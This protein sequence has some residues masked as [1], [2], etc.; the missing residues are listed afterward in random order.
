MPKGVL[1]C[2]TLSFTRVE[3]TH[4]FA[5]SAPEFML[6]SRHSVIPYKFLLP[7]RFC[8]SCCA[9]Q[10]SG[11]KFCWK[12]GSPSQCPLSGEGAG[13]SSPKTS[14]GKPLLLQG[15]S[16][17]KSFEDY[18]ACKKKQQQS[19][20]KFR[21]KKKVKVNADEV[22]TINIGLMR[23]CENDLKAIWGKRL[24]IQVVKS[25]GY[26]RILSKGMEKW[27][28]F[29]RKFDPEED[30]VLLFEDGSHAVCLPGQEEDFQLEKYKTELGKDYKRITMYLCTTA[31]FEMSEDSNPTNSGLNFFEPNDV[32]DS[33]LANDIE[34][35]SV[36]TPA[37]SSLVKTS[38]PPLS[39]ESPSTSGQELDHSCSNV[40]SAEQQILQDSQLAH[41]LQEWENTSES[42]QEITDCSTTVVAE[43]AQIVKILSERVDRMQEFFLVS[44]RCA[45]FSR[46][47]ALWQRQT[48]KSPPTSVLKVHFNGEAGIDTGAMSQGF[49]AEVISDM[50]REVF[51]DG[52]PTDSTYYVQN[53]TF[54]TCGEI[55]A[56]S[57]AQGGPPP[58]FLEQCV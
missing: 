15:K 23:N 58:C 56:V 39:Y 18:M 24:P 19:G 51:P 26:A 42:F 27:A 22:V 41:M 9:K 21:L 11:V 28:A 37:R 40:Q 7:S 1:H 48:K 31:E 44:R 55:V 30:H 52:S 46:T 53:G 20:A 36:T 38:T 45:P 16:K 33:S 43:P 3:L 47:I 34:S 2:D 5:S 4:S 25:A 35:A 8:T 6:F 29:D 12:C 54:R 13:T 57:L 14:F 17:A 10:R 50:G 32:P 49:L